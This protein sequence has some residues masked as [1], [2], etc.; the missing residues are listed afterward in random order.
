MTYPYELRDTLIKIEGV[1]AVRGPNLVLRDI[2]VEIKN[3]V[4]PDVANQ[5]QV[6]GVLGP[7]GIGKTTLFRILA[8]L[9]LPSRGRV[10][11][12]ER[13]L[14]V[15]AGMV[16]VVFQHYPL[17]EHRTVL[18]NLVIAARHAGIRD[19]ESR[20]RTLLERFKLG[21]RVDAWPSE[22]SGGQRQR[23]AI[24]Q[25]L[26]CGHTY[27]LMDEPFSG[28]DPISKH[29]ACELIAEV[30][31]MDERNTMIIVTHDI[32]EAVKVSDTLWLMGRDRAPSGEPIPGSRIVETY[33]LIDRDLAWHPGIE[34]TAPFDGFVRELSEKF[35]TL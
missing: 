3:V 32:R 4:R 19:G 17:F 28:L 12:G 13:Q 10:L 16:G 34:R 7:S 11:V 20:A 31:R 21:E 26:L 15:R 35:Q 18:G 24:L 1:H 14:P 25:Q 6:I 2:A 22:L 5:G 30:S 8:G 33:N 27:L 23:V 29:D 9:D